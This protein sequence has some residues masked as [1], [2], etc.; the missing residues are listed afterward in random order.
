MDF[1]IHN[2]LP[3]REEHVIQASL[4]IEADMHTLCLHQFR[5]VGL[6]YT[7]R[8]LHYNSSQDKC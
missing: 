5:I 8:H 2:E 7:F 4:N 3:R 1:N 6:A